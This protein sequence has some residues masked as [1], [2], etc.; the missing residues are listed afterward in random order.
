MSSLRLD[1]FVT[2][3]A[4]FITITEQAKWILNLHIVHTLSLVYT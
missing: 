3:T 2:V 1:L 4:P